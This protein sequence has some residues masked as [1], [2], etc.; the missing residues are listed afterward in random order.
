MS[1]RITT[2]S[3]CDLPND[4]YRERNI[5]VIGLSF[6]LDGQEYK[7]GPDLKITSKEFYGQ[8]REGKLSST[9]QVNS[10]D[11]MAF[12][13]PLLAEGEDVLHIAFSSG[14]SGTYE[15][16]R[17]GVEELKEKYPDRK[18]IIIDSL[19]AS[20]GEGLLTYYADENRKAGLPIEENAAWLENH[21]LNLCHWFTVDD[22]MFLHRGGRVSKTSAI[23]G[24]LLGIKP[25]LH[26]DDEGHLILVSKARGRAGS[27]EALIEKL[28]TTANEDIKDQMVFISHGDCLEEAQSLA[29]KLRK[30]FGIEK[31]QISNIGAVIGSHSGPGTVA[32]FFLGKQR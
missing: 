21:K 28:K 15:S 2:D 4:F 29:V 6:Q 16:C 22:L 31:I 11:F 5:P 24:S 17:R 19:A 1:Y 26:V 9:M 8:L 23:L 20:A 32:L 18:V 27:I 25:V 30:D 14:L 7:E 13:E 3:T 12:I 10:F